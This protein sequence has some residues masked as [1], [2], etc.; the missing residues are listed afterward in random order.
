MSDVNNAA[1]VNTTSPST[2]ATIGQQV[3]ALVSD[4]IASIPG[5]MNPMRVVQAVADAAG[6]PAELVGL[7][8]GA[9]PLWTVPERS[10][11]PTPADSTPIYVT[12][13]AK[14]RRTTA[15][16]VVPQSMPT[17]NIERAN[18]GKGTT[19]MVG[20]RHTSEQDLIDNIVKMCLSR[21]TERDRDPEQCRVLTFPPKWLST[22]TTPKDK[23]EVEMAYLVLTLEDLATIKTRITQEFLEPWSY[24]DSKNPCEAW[25]LVFVV[26]D[27]NSQIP[28]LDVTLFKPEPFPGPDN[29]RPTT[30][31]LTKEEFD[32]LFDKQDKDKSN[33]RGRE[34]EEEA[35]AEEAKAEETKAEETK[36]EEDKAEEAKE[37]EP[38]EA[39]PKAEEPKA[40]EPLAKKAK[41]SP[42]PTAEEAA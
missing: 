30:K 33:K 5:A 23:I 11:T 6:A 14:A 8:V 38:K 41:V 32:R 37:E 31:I 28:D 39:E 10:A 2:E 7:N 17:I 21:E 36:A 29:N 42:E 18:D 25:H 24:D 1:A 4:T 27:D 9:S 16:M 15:G 22:P 20:T 13:H 3:A 35:K 26:V 40:E 19:V 12:A 34:E